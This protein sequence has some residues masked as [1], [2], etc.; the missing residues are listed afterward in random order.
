MKEKQHV[1][2]DFKDNGALQVACATSSQFT[3]HKLVKITRALLW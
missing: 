1:I 2:H 3:P